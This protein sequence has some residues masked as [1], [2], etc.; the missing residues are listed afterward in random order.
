MNQLTK[1]N[2]LD[3]TCSRHDLTLHWTIV[4]F[5]HRVSQPISRRDDE[6]Q[7]R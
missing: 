7:N 3:D 5:Q 6:G 4:K 2:R 1:L